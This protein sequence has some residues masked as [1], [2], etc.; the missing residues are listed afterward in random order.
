MV[1]DVIYRQVAFSVLI[2]V[3][4]EV[5]VRI[6]AERTIFGGGAV[7]VEGKVEGREAGGGF[8]QPSRTIPYHTMGLINH[9][10]HW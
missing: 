10:A 7:R 9:W 3:F 2:Y 6:S 1:N 8:K 5:V 4:R